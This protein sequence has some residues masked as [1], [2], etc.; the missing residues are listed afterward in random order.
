M[1]KAA[2]MLELTCQAMFRGKNTRIKPAYTA[3]SRSRTKHNV[4]NHSQNN[5]YDE[6][7]TK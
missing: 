7:E 5:I 2:T 4:D 6:T 1:T 3:D